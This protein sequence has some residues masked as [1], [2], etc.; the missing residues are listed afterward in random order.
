MPRYE[1]KL[2]KDDSVPYKPLPSGPIVAEMLDKVPGSVEC[3]ICHSTS[4]VGKLIDV[5]TKCPVCG[6]GGV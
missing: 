2:P 6:Y 3:P 1:L 5:P 4:P